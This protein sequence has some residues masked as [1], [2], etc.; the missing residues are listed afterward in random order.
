[1]SDQA[2]EARLARQEEDSSD[3]D[4]FDSY[5]KP[6][7][8]LGL[9]PQ[10]FLGIFSQTLLPSPVIQWILP[11]RLRSKHHNDVVFIGQTRVQIIEAV[12]GGYLED[13]S[14]K[15]NFDGNII[16]ARVMNVNTDLPWE[17]QLQSGNAYN[18]PAQLLILSLDLRELQFIYCSPNPGLENGEDFI[19]YR[20]ALPMDVSLAQR[21]GKHLA[22]DPK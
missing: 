7:P 9:V 4:L 2:P 1:M 6:P 16:S 14:E 12:V 21:F 20:R 17:T 11:A 10:D 5:Y 13:R 3:G 19:S 18:G 8:D 22:V 15:A